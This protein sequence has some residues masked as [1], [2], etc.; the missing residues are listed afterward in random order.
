MGSPT[1]KV[2]RR[3]SGETRP[4]VDCVTQTTHSLAA[5]TPVLILDARVRPPEYPARLALPL[6][7]QLSSRISSNTAQWSSHLV[8]RSPHPRPSSTQP[9]TSATRLP[10][11]PTHTHLQ[12]ALPFSS[13]QL[14]FSF[15]MRV[16]TPE[17]PTC[18]PLLLQL[19]L[20]RSQLQLQLCFILLAHLSPWRS[21]PRIR[22]TSYMLPHLLAI[23][24]ASAAPALASTLQL[25]FS[26]SPRCER[27]LQRVPLAFLSCSHSRSQVPLNSPS[28][29]WR[30]SSA[31]ANK[32]PSLS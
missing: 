14:Q 7:L 19:S 1:V 28:C 18:L 24:F 13:L 8:L 3:S 29:C 11:N 12:L 6:Q 22:P 27:T 17:Y 26:Y 32:L 23:Y 9:S 10:I 16:H 20:S 2:R 30:T 5:P 21:S 31:P 4:G 25:Q 15:S